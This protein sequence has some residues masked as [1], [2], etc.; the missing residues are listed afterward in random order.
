MNSPTEATDPTVEQGN[1]GT[2]GHLSGQKRPRDYGEELKGLPTSDDEDGKNDSFPAVKKQKTDGV[3][4]ADDSGLDDGEIVESSPAPDNGLGRLTKESVHEPVMQDFSEDGEVGSSAADPEESNAP[5][6][7]FFIDKDGGKPAP[8]SGWNEGVSLGTRTSF[9]NGGTRLFPAKPSTA[10]PSRGDHKDGGEGED[11]EEGEGERDIAEYEKKEEITK[12]QNQIKDKKTKTFTAGNALWNY[13]SSPGISV[14]Y[15]DDAL[16]PAF[17]V[18]KLRVWT[19]ALLK[20]NSSSTAGRLTPEVIR[21]G[22]MLQYSGNPNL[23]NGRRKQKMDFVGVAKKVV[24]TVNLQALIAD[25]RSN[26]AKDAKATGENTVVSSESGSQERMDEAVTLLSSDG[27]DDELQQQRKYFPGVED[28]SRYCLSCS[29][30]GHKSRECPQLHCKFCE[31]QGHT[32][33]G[34]PTKQRCSKCRQLGHNSRSCQEKLAL[35]VGEQGG[36]AFCGAEHTEEQCTEIWR[37]FVLSA[38]AHKKVK[39]I[40]AFC[41]TC[42]AQGHYGQECGLPDRG[43]KVTGRTTWSQAN[44]I[45][46]VDPASPDIAI[47]WANVDLSSSPHGEFH[48]RGRAKRPTHTHF[49]SSD[50]SEGEDLVHAPVQRSGPRG[51]IRI[52]SNIG[53]VPVVGADP[54]RGGAKNKNRKPRGDGEVPPPPPPQ[55]HPQRS[56][57]S[58]GSSWQPPL[59]SGPPP[60]MPSN[61]FRGS[62]PSAALAS[63]PPRPQTF[64]QSSNSRGANRGGSNR[65]FSNGRGGQNSRGGRGGSRGNGRGRGRGRGN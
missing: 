11:E 1:S 35:A 9:R 40:P 37:S 14:K 19:A 48:I 57:S 29:G 3:D 30:M 25:V 5:N 54:T 2:V 22:F 15:E 28:P 36:C 33:F 32:S 52:A 20:A 43:G 10:A 53:S 31:S 13:P 23:F 61:V 59:P 65:G 26:A 7:P 34:C 38:E 47:G 17:W 64:N 44:R 12:P 63:L 21:M 16:N 42:G 46:Y 18:E 49:V 56:R 6:E 24:I 62:L 55:S 4:D 60:S 27:E 51:E 58:R 50:E 39:D 45:L 41:Y 8:R